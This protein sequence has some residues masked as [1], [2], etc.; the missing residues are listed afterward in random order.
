MATTTAALAASGTDLHVLLPGDSDYRDCAPWNRAGVSAPAAVIKARTAQDVA[1]AVR[2]AAARGLRVAVRSSGHGAVPLDGSTLLVH[3]GAMT[4]FTIDPARRTVR[5]AAG[6]AW[7]SVLEEAARFGLAPICG[8][9]PGIG[10]VGYLS[11]GGLGP[12]ARTYGVGSDYVR[13]AQVVVGDGRI[14]SATPTEN[15]DLFWGVR[16]GKA[17]LGIVTDMEVDLVPLD[18]FYGGALW[19]DAADTGRVLAA[20]RRMCVALPEQGTSS[21]AI[22]R[23]PPLDVLPAPIAGRQTLA[24]RY[25][26]VGDP[27]DGES[28]LA[29]IRRAATPILD[30][31]TQRPSTQ[32]GAIHSDPVAPSATTVRSALLGPIDDT[33]LDTLVQATRPE[34]NR[35]LIVELRHLGGAVAHAPRQPSAFCHR[36][37][38]YSLFLSG[39]ALPDSAPADDHAGELLR[40]MAPWTEP[41]LLPNFSASIDPDD[42]DRYYDSDTRHWLKELGDHYDPAHTLHTGQVA[43][44][45]LPTPS[46]A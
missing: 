11:G 30:D 42:I 26:W 16:G 4:D 28:F 31:I 3:T 9:A 22:L 29:D 38:T 7:Q 37:A 35:Q 46:P 5:L 12:L 18:S 44:H 33:T 14:L 27:N 8:S 23:L 15:A 17:T 10:A 43:R 6:V 41:G 25:G 2:Y 13:T 34:V 20:W 1:A 21:A 24:I 32:I 40:A 45:P 39:A 36:D 19:F